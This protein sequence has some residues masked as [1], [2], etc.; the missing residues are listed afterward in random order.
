MRKLLFALLLLPVA[1][2]LGSCAD[3]GSHSQAVVLLID[4]SGTYTAELEKAHAIAK[5]LL[6]TLQSGDSLCVA[7][8]D[9]GSF[10]E[11]DI[12]H[13]VTFDTQPSM[14]NQQ[15]R[16]FIKA[17]DDFV[18]N[19]KSSPYTDVTGGLLQ[20]VE[21]LVETGSPKRTI[22]VF[23]DLEEELAKGYVRDFP[24]ELK[25][26]QVVAL[27]VTKLRQDILDPR[28]YEKRLQDWKLRIEKGG[29]SFR[30]LNDLDRLERLLE[31]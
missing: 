20:A 26:C 14:L 28:K 24:L 10:S 27:N 25:G 15:K 23:S 18:G 12:I 8:I 6:G 3:N 19:T 22:L 31:I 1:L 30:V 13:K 16:A 11:K 2:G 29:G 17:L 4:T 21:Y 9:T 5:F 7:R